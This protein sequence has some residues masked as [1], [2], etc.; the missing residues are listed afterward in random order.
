MFARDSLRNGF[1]PVFSVSVEIFPFN[2]FLC[3]CFATLAGWTRACTPAPPSGGV[4]V[5]RHLTAGCVA[6]SEEEDIKNKKTIRI[7]F[8]VSVCVVC[9]RSSAVFFLFA[10]QIHVF[11]FF[12]FLQFRSCVTMRMGLFPDCRLLPSYSFSVCEQ[13]A[14]RHARMIS[15]LDAR[16]YCISVKGK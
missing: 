8:S 14:G 4:P 2:F 3:V 13:C 6:S 7:V 16:V 15:C 1:H 9:L 12:L 10:W 5:C 11:F